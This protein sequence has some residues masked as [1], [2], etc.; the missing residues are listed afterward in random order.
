MTKAPIISGDTSKSWVTLWRGYEEAS[1]MRVGSW[2]GVSWK[3][4]L[5]LRLGSGPWFRRRSQQPV[6]G[7]G[8]G[9]QEESSSQVHYQGHR[10]R[11]GAST[12]WV[13]L[14]SI[15]NA[16]P[17][18]LLHSRRL[19][20]SHHL[21]STLAEDHPRVCW[22]EGGRQRDHHKPLGIKGG[23][24]HTAYSGPGLGDHE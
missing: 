15:Q 22:P 21:L 24:M 3:W 4:C 17:D 13:F 7:A 11:Q 12:A 8:Q 14:R 19:P 20:P 2:F 1:A 9:R 23:K 5:R 6:W 10:C 16:S 18:V